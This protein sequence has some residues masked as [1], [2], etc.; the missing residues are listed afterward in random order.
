MAKLAH[1][2]R[3]EAAL[4]VLE[5]ALEKPLVPGELQSWLEYAG[6]AFSKLEDPL[7]AHIEQ[8][9]SQQFADIS[10]QDAEMLQRVEQLRAVDQQLLEQYDRLA[11]QVDGIDTKLEEDHETETRLDPIV[12]RFADHGLKLVIDIRKQE[13][14]VT[15]WYLEAFQRDRGVAD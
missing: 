2:Q 15:T 10:K 8:E 6:Q 7:R 1:K 13:S 3:L 4:D 9:H 12:E 5:A 11:R 14:A